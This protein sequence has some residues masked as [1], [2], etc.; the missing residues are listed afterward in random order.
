MLLAAHTFC[1]FKLDSNHIASFYYI[2]FKFTNGH[3]TLFACNGT[4]SNKGGL[5]EICYKLTVR[6]VA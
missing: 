2:H 4:K 1:C 5:N 3:E 6:F